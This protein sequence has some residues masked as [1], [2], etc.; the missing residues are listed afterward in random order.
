MGGRTP[1]PNCGE[2][3]IWMASPPLEEY[4]DESEFEGL[5]CEECG[6][7]EENGKVVR[8]GWRNEHDE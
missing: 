1:C 4:H 8:D 3:A 2:P 5:S 6:Y 7:V